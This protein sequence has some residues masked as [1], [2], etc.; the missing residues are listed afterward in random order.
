VLWTNLAIPSVFE[1]AL[2]V[3]ILF[4]EMYISDVNG[5]QKF[6]AWLE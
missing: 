5:N 6:L 3:D 1:N 2:K 4:F